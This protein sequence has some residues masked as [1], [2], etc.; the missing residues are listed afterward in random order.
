MNIATLS[1]EITTTNPWEENIWVK[2]VN[3]ILKN[4]AM[5]TIISEPLE[6]NG[7]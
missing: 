1:N 3:I 5:W 2:I 4:K 6:Y 7:T